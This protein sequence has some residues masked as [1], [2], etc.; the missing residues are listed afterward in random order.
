MSQDLPSYTPPSTRPSPAPDAVVDAANDLLI[1]CQ[2]WAPV[3]M[4]EMT[5]ETISAQSYASLCNTVIDGDITVAAFWFGAV[6]GIVAWIFLIRPTF[7][8]LFSVASW[9]WRRLFGSPAGGRA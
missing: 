6:F 3:P 9:S 7:S 4:A 1:A 8:I 2:N 5:P